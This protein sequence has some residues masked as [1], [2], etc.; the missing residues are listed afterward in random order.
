MR[1]F[2]SDH[3]YKLHNQGFHHIIQFA[4]HNRQ[5]SELFRAITKELAELYG[6]AVEQT[7]TNGCT[8]KTFNPNYRYEQN[9]KCKRRRIYL[10]NETDATLILLK[11]Q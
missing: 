8:Y 9:Q 6:P 3:R 5:D 2:K 4:W 7:W 1:L 10:K 11:A